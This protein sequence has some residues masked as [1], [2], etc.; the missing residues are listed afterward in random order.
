MFEESILAFPF[1]LSP[2]T[3]ESYIDHVLFSFFTDGT[4]ASMYGD[5]NFGNSIKDNRK[6]FNKGVHTL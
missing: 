3:K 5:N 4:S 2:G 1:S 6:L